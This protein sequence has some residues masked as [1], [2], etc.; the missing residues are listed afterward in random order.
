[1]PHSRRRVAIVARVGVAIV[2]VVV[3]PHDTPETYLSDTLSIGTFLLL[4]LFWDCC[5]CSFYTV[6]NLITICELFTRSP[7]Q[8]ARVVVVVVV[9]AVSVA[10][11]VVLVAESVVNVVVGV[12]ADGTVIHIFSK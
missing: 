5:Y 3:R 10:V 2:A 12:S 6:K 8:R 4:W 9:V 11:F 1:L 7:L